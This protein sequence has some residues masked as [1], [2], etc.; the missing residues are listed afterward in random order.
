MPDVADNPARSR[1]ELDVDGTVAFATY[2]MDGDTLILLHT[3]VPDA[4]SGHGVGS[5]LAR[6]VL[7]G[8]RRRGLK[9]LPRCEFMAAY[10]GRH[11]EYRDLLVPGG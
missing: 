5:A 10:I 4:L 8:A 7:D 1:F 6:G 3:E 9:V 11:P 2:A